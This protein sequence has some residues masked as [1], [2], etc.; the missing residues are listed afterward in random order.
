VRVRHPAQADLAGVL[1]LVRAA[2]EAVL[3]ESDWRRRGIGEALLATV[4]AEFFRR[5][6]HRVALGVDAENPT[7]ATRLYERVGMRRFWEAVVYEK[8]IRG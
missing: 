5:G 7:G 4:F 3:E 2:D 6:E 1:G 8:E